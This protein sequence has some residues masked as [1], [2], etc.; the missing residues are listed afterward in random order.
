MADILVVDDEEEIS[1]F[2][3]QF[4]SEFGFKTDYCLSGELAFERFNREPWKLVIVDLKLS[5]NISGIQVLKVFKEK[6]PKALMI[7]MSGYVDM[8]MRQEVE[9]LG[10]HAFFSKP[11][12]L[13][14]DIF[15]EKAKPFLDLIQAG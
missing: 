5:T 6:F 9:N 1:S 2:L 3:A 11:D 13:Q 15:L 10:V 12:D 8:G 4:L 14:L 7:A